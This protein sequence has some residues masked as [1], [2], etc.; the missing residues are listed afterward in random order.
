MAGTPAEQA[1][2]AR[3]A[4]LP[5]FFLFLP[6]RV[7]RRGQMDIFVQ[8]YKL[9]KSRGEEAFPREKMN[10]KFAA[11]GAAISEVLLVLIG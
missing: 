6:V 7:C 11:H 4:C 8:C 3:A 5:G 1:G 2:F 10:A 9:L